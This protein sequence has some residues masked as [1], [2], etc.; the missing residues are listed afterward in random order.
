[1]KTVISKLRQLNLDK[2]PKGHKTASQWA[3]E[4]NLGP[5][6]MRKYLSA[7]IKAGIVGVKNYRATSGGVTRVIPHYFEIN[8]PTEAQHNGNA[9]R[10]SVSSTGRR[11]KRR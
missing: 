7:G 1:M 6:Q 10:S 5:S 3:D 8:E 11:P 4:L 2:I 9:D